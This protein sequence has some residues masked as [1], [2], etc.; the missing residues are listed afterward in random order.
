MHF[1]LG[2]IFVVYAVNTEADEARRGET[3][4]LLASLTKAKHR[5]SLVHECEQLRLASSHGHL[6][7]EVSDVFE[8]KEIPQLLPHHPGINHEIP[9]SPGSKPF[10]GMIYN[11][12]ETKLRYLNEYI[13]RMFKRGW[14]HL[15]KSP[16][17]SLILFI[18]KP[19]GSL[20]LC[21]DYRK[22]KAMTIKNRY[23]LPLIS[24][25]LDRIKNAKYYTKLDLRD[26]FNQ[27]YI[28]L[29]DE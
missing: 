24:E 22:L 7:A 9:L 23:S 11:L 27:L 15:S 28:A 18:K 1:T 8:D 29:G 13:D 6:W 10:Y 5:P 2:N 26:A 25:L 16:F 12:S 4:S 20:H 19:D 17:G 21:V 3:V 14:I